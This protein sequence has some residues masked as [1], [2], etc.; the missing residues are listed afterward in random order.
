MN[1]DIPAFLTYC[2]SEYLY[3]LTEGFGYFTPITVFAISSCPG[4]TIK[5]H[6]MADDTVMFSNIPVS[7]LANNKAAPKIIEED[8]VCSLC[9][10]ENIVVNQY[11]YLA[12]IEHCAVWENDG[13]LW[14]K[15][16]YVFTVEWVD[17]KTQCHLIELE[18]GNYVFWPSERITWGEDVPEKIPGYELPRA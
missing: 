17:A 7:A 11:E 6:I 15:G 2:R 4:E 13:P 8:C 12:N 14:R 16:I 10:S 9:P 1:V 3:S 18:D 5:F